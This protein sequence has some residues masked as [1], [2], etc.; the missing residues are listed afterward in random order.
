MAPSWIAG[1][2]SV[3]QGVPVAGGDNEITSDDYLDE[4]A[5]I[6]LNASADQAVV[7][8]LIEGFQQATNSLTRRSLAM[9]IAQHAASDDEEAVDC[10]TS[11]YRIA[12]SDV[13]L[14]P[15]LLDAL[16]VL[17][18]HNGIA[19]AELGALITRLKL[20][21]SR[22]LLIK[23]AKTIVRLDTLRLSK[24]L[25]DKLILFE[26]SPDMFVK[27]EATVQIAFLAL[28]D[29]LQ[30][31]TAE[32]MRLGLI[33]AQT[34]FARAHAIE[35]QRPDAD[36]FACLLNIVLAFDEMSEDRSDIAT[37]LRVS[38]DRM[39]S[40][41]AQRWWRTYRSHSADILVAR[42]LGVADAM[43]MAATAV[44]HSDEWAN[45]DD[46]L[47]ELATLYFSF[48]GDSATEDAPPSAYDYAAVANVLFLPRLGQVLRDVVTRKR[49]TRAIE[50]Y[51]SVHGEDGVSNALRTFEHIYAGDSPSLASTLARSDTQR[52]PAAISGW[53]SATGKNPVDLVNGFK[54]AR[55]HGTE[56]EWMQGL[57]LRPS[58][59]PIDGPWFFGGS[60]NVDEVVRQILMSAAER[61]VTYPQHKL[62]R[63][64]TILETIT[65]FAEYVRDFL[66]DYTRCK[67]DNGLG[68]DA[69]ERDLQV[70]LFRWLKQ[71]FGRLAS[72]EV[73]PVGGGR[74]DTGLKFE[75]CIFP[76]EV[77][78]EFTSITK[79]HIHANYI[80]QA[81]IYA[82]VTDRVSFL[83]VLDLRASNASGHRDARKRRANSRAAQPPS[84]YSL[85]ASFWV[86][87]LTRDE[88]LADATSTAVI[89]GLIPGN[90]PI[91]SSTTA[92]SRRP[93]SSR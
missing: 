70:D 14:G 53:A 13:F 22:Y 51:I 76:I 75:D 31:N 83:M 15:A 10:L 12:R 9:A 27:S 34:Y 26:R 32:E 45:V 44:E 46:A 36:L 6:T 39:R 92:Y 88:Q 86:D 50:D 59:L 56:R 20:D 55:L 17:A 43:T 2:V 40:V 33:G 67:A 16:S 66:P 38:V 49:L 4:L 85:A 48:Q 82:A 11:A 84:L 71:R 47:I 3:W 1:F 19:R 54:I 74:P 21:D 72:Y 41:L 28:A 80:T 52:I 68:S 90:R 37:K 35:E 23:A 93:R 79:E 7:P 73:T 87:G 8:K 30:A 91:P 57:G 89:V 65:G 42:A 77:K 63:L 78:H 24:D 61:L 25:R 69:S 29:A 60:P 64:V 62:Q 5:Q 58:S 18:T 81:D